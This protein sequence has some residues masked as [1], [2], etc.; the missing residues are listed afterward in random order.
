MKGFVFDLDN[1]LFDRYATLS[2]V[3]ENGY[4]RAKKYINPAYDLQMAT[5]HLCHTEALYVHLGWQEIYEAL[6][7]EHFFDAD[8]TPDYKKA[9][10]FIAD[11]FMETAINHPFTFD[12]LKKLRECGY[13]LAILT[14]NDNYEMQKRKIELLGIADLFDEIVVSGELSLKMSGHTQ[15]NKYF[16]P[17]PAIFE[18]TANLL[19]EKPTDLYY[20]GDNPRMDVIGA[21]NG[22][23]IPVWIKSRSPWSL[24]NDLMPE[25]CF[26]TIEGLLTLI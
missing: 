5:D 10:K 8:N 7:D 21:Y 22:G 17:Q 25:H 18:Y 23:Y 12:V 19:G 26:K 1:T 20:V 9:S 2:K 6:I 24:P 3:M 13:K 11:G 15:D 4:N 14:N 16:K